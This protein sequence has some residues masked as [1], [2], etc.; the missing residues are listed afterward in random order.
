MFVA[1][2]QYMRSMDLAY[3]TTNNDISNE[4]LIHCLSLSEKYLADIHIYIFTSWYLFVYIWAQHCIDRS[5]LR[6][7][8]FW[9]SYIKIIK[10]PIQM[11]TLSRIFASSPFTPLKIWQTTRCQGDILKMFFV[12][13]V[14]DPQPL[15]MQVKRDYHGSTVAVA[16]YVH[17]ILLLVVLIYTSSMD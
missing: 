9:S 10:E 15:H 3:R 7:R 6:T 11:R 5:W 16:P 1:C 8:G 2:D 14:L 4:F 17:T 12:L 13:V